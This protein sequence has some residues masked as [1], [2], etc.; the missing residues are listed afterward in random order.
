[1][2]F[3]FYNSEDIDDEDLEVP[4]AADEALGAAMIC[5]WKN[6]ETS[7][8]SDPLIAAWSMCVMPEV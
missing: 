6:R 4:H 3:S 7:I 8:I 1:M 5:L 2:N